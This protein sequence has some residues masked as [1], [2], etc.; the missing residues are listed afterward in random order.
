MNNIN[1]NFFYKLKPEKILG[2]GSH[3]TVILTNNNNYTV[4]IYT[5]RT[6][7]LIMLVS[8]LNFFINYKNIP[9][10]I[11]KSYYLTEKKNSLNRYIVNNN[12]PEQFSFNNE[13]HNIKPLLFEVMKTYEITLKDFIN[14]LSKNNSINNDNKINILISLFYQGLYTL[15]WLYIKKGIVHLDINSDNFFVEKTTEENFIININNIEFKIPT[16]GYNLIISDFGF[17]RSIELVDYDEYKYN[18]RINLESFDIHP[19]NDVINF[20]KIFKKYFKIYNIQ[21]SN[22][23]INIDN[24]NMRLIN[25]TQQDYRDMIRSYYKKKDDLKLNIKKFKNN[26]FNHF[27]KYILNDYS[28]D[29]FL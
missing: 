25:R 9:N 5:K 17:A 19:Y 14:K 16:L 15:L 24:I 4:K 22:L 21:L 3:G 18:I 29:T 2:K 8:I 6:K 23:D 20:I 7:N 27:R 26:Y 11:Y 28:V 10:S 12:L 13:E 1:N